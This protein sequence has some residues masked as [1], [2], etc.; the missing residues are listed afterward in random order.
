[1]MNVKFVCAFL[2]LLSFVEL[3][4]DLVWKNTSLDF[5]AKHGQDKIEAYY[6]F[7]N[8]GKDTVHISQV[9]TSCGCTVPTLDKKDYASGESG[10]I[11]AVFTVGNRKGKQSKTLK[12]ITQGEA[13]DYNLVLNVNIPVFVSMKPSFLFW[14]VNEGDEEKKIDVTFNTPK[15]VKITELKM[16]NEYFSVRKKE[17]EVGKK[18]ELWVKPASVNARYRAMLEIHT[19]SNIESTKKSRIYFAVK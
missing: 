3:Q 13:K 18:Y 8:E 19:D 14:R 11:K 1:M 17:V 12:V 15:P 2:L 5:D 6:E 10:K 7:K 9:K 4:A 16:N